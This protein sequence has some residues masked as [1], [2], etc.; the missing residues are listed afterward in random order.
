MEDL[1]KDYFI[2]TSQEEPQRCG[3]DSVD[4]ISCP[5]CDTQVILARTLGTCECVDVKTV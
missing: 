4:V 2:V 1:S 3:E 5:L